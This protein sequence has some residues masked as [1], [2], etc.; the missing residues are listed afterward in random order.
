MKTIYLAG[1]CF[2]GTQKY[3]DQFDGVVRTRVGYANGPGNRGSHVEGPGNKGSHVQESGGSLPG[4]PERQVSYQEVCAGSGHAE[5]VELVYDEAVISLT[6]LLEYYFLVID[7]L[8]VNR[9]GN[10]RGIQYR[11]GIYYTE[12]S[13]K[14]E[15]RAV[16][17]RQE[18][19]AGGPLAVELGPL[20][21]FCPA[22]EYHQKYLDKNPGGY[23]H[24]PQRFFALDQEEPAEAV[25]SEEDLRARIGDIA[26]EVT[27]HAATERAFT[28]RYDEYFEKGIYV[29]VVTGQVLFSSEDKYNSGCGWPAF[30]RPVSGDALTEHK[31]ESY[32]MVRVEVRS[33]QGRS[34]LGHVFNDGPRDQGGLRYCI[35][36]A[37][38]R[39]IPYEDLDK[40]GYG[41]WKGIL[42][43]LLGLVSVRLLKLYL[44]PVIVDALGSHWGKLTFSIIYTF[45]FIAFFPLLLNLYHKMT[46]K[47]DEAD[48]TDYR[49][50]A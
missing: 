31:D 1:G 17:R 14:E 43:C 16:Y 8:A 28:G 45:Y 47:M 26:Y 23:C 10:D 2:W 36:S 49:A 6:K 11:T 24:I 7:P 40:E 15:I 19:L 18:D 20:L 42:V 4:W 30:T 9:Q 38:L 35:N 46:D 27:Q 37:A 41:S 25:E 3:F 29:D 12:E 50:A 33:A 39:F 22:E 34:H 48:K 13:Q 44:S 21:N 5:T 32:G